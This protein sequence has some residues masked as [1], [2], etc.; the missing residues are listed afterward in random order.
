[1]SHL[2]YDLFQGSSQTEWRMVAGEVDAPRIARETHK[3]IRDHGSREFLFNVT[4]RP[5][6]TRDAALGGCGLE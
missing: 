6:R 5:R 3:L 4:T 2:C 1:M